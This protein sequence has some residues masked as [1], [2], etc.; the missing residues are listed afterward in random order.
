MIGVD[1]DLSARTHQ[2][3]D[4]GPDP[5]GKL[6]GGL[7]GEGDAEDLLGLESMVPDECIDA[8]RN[9]RRLAGSGTRHDSQGMKGGLH[10]PLLILGG[11]HGANASLPSGHSGH[12]ER[13]RQ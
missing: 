6:L 12:T 5:V 3:S 11:N 10:D 9:S 13:T 1:L 4:G 7:V 8:H 2:G